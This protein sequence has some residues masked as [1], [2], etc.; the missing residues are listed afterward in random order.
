VKLFQSLKKP[1][2]SICV[3]CR[4]MV[5]SVFASNLFALLQKSISANY[6]VNFLML[7]GS[8]I[9]AQRQRLAELAIEQNSNYVMW[10]DSDMGFPVDI[11][12]SLLVHKKDIVACNYSTRTPPYKGVAY[13]T[14]GNWDSWINNENTNILDSV[15]GVGMGCMLV[16]TDVYKSLPKP[17]FEIFYS[18]QYSTHLGED[19]YFCIKARE[20]KYDIWVD[21]KTSKQI[22]HFGT[23]EFQSN[24]WQSATK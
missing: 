20:H 4:D 15:E 21:L 17:W 3:P 23:A 22:K 12:D 19:F 5:H 11:I 8:L 24:L 1:L 13:K 2:I 18:D 10:L 16:N 6:D 9:S 14:I 7:Q